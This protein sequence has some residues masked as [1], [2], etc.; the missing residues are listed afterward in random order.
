[1]QQTPDA[2]ALRGRTRRRIRA[3]ALLGSA[4]ALV[5]AGVVAEVTPSA[6]S[7]A[8]TTVYQAENATVHD[9]SVDHDHAGYHGTGFVNLDNEVGSY[10]QWSVPAGQAGH[11]TLTFRYA[12]GTGTNRPVAVSVNGGAPVMV[13]FPGTGAWTTWATATT[14]VDL[15]AGTNSVKVTSSTANGAPNLDEL[16]VETAGGSGDVTPP[17]APGAPSQVSVTANSVT[18]SWTASTD[19]TGVTG[20]DLLADGQVCGTAAGTATTGTCT[21]LTA[22]ADHS[23]TV[24]ARDAAGNVS[25]DSPALA[26]HT[27]AGGGGPFPGDPNLVSMFNGTGLDG[28][29]PHSTKGWDVQDGAIHGTGAGGRGW[30]YY[31]KQVGTFRWI[32]DVR[33][34]KGDHA[35]TVL[36]WGTTD[37]IRDALSAIQFQPPNG[38]HWDYRPGHNNGGGNEFKQI[39]HTKIDIHQW[40]QCELVGNMTTG[41]AKMACGQLTGSATT[42]CKA[43]E[44]LDF[45]DATA[46]RVG[47][48]AIQVHNSGIQDEY[49]GLYLESP[50]VTAPDQ[51][52]TT[53]C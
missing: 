31:N 10:V 43:V 26:V 11:A 40:S 28:W 24:R 50:V 39:D 25:P 20:Y 29:T 1:M 7:A 22:D 44:V 15:T 5:T 51:F 37:P 16:T 34:L 21:G 45:K 12:N 48:L 4:M 13:N 41:V 6:A 3:F 42:T 9:G 17:S 36:I 32:F 30:I 47:P 33:Q 23:I 27:P 18:V 8:D 35:P 14:A 52:I 46:G 53:H 49:K 2:R 38:G 19:D